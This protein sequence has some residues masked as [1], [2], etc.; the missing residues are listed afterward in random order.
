MFTVGTEHANLPP[1]QVGNV[2][3]D[4]GFSGLFSEIS[5]NWPAVLVEASQAHLR[6]SL[7]AARSATCP[8]LPPAHTGAWS[9][10]LCQW[11][12]GTSVKRTGTLSYPIIYS[13]LGL[14]VTQCEMCGL[15][16]ATVC[17]SVS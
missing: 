7:P 8:P 12:T 17:V 3:D 14:K 9:L 15:E 4:L 1:A 11:E 6:L 10:S 13:H 16:A 5:S 2:V